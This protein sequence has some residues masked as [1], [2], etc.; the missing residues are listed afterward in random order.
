MYDIGFHLSSQAIR[1]QL[2][3]MPCE[4]YLI[5]LIHHC[6]PKAAFRRAALDG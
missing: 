2:A 5:R 3:A 6:N 4:T 1:R